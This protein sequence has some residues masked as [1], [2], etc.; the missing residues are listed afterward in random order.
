LKK[1]KQ[2]WDHWLSQG[3][4]RMNYQLSLIEPGS[5]RKITRRDEFLKKGHKGKNGT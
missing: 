1:H 4:W 5:N 2:T 3:G